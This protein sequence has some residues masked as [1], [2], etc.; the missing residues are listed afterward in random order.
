LA[1]E[2]L[3]AALPLLAPAGVSRLVLDGGFIDGAWL[4]QLHT[5]Y[6]LEICLRVREDMTFFADAVGQTRLRPVLPGESPPPWVEA[7]LPKIK[8]GRRPL[9]RRVMLCPELTSWSQLGRPAEA[10][11]IEDRFPEGELRHLVIACIGAAPSD[12]LTRLAQWRS[13]WAIEETF[14]VFDRWQ[15]LG[16]LFPCREGFA[17]AWVHFSFLAYTLLFLFDRW[18]QDHPS[19][20]AP[21]QELLAI[22]GGNYALIGLGDF[23]LILIDYHSVWQ[24]RRA[25]VLAKLNFRSPP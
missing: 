6:G 16:R 20:L 2:L 24:A 22:R 14:M 10:L 17:R 7:P 18:A 15:G 25:E 21:T 19:P 1:K 4:S 9:Q 23:T 8:S 13:R 11:V 3:K 12:P 5:E